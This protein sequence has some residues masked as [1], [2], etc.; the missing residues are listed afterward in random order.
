M[1]GVVVERLA[2]TSTSSFASAFFIAP[3]RS[4]VVALAASSS[5]GAFRT[6]TLTCDNDAAKSSTL[7]A[8]AANVSSIDRTS[9]ASSTSNALE[10]S[11]DARAAC[12]LVRSGTRITVPI[13]SAASPEP[14]LGS[15][16]AATKGAN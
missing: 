12:A 4:R 14:R 1:N 6:V 3:S 10:L 8:L 7:C 15:K 5:L 16:P 9:H 13:E 2:C 11:A